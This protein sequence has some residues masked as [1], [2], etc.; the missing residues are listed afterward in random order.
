MPGKDYYQILGVKRDAT[1]KE[2]RQAYRKLARKYHPD[3]NPGNKAAEARFKEIGEAYEVLSDKEKRAKYD[4]FGD[5]WQ[6]AGARAPGGGA[7]GTPFDFGG[8]PGNYQVHFEDLGGISEE[9]FGGIFDQIFGAGRARQAARRPRRGRDY[10]QPVEVT[11]EEAFHGTTRIMQLEGTEP[12]PA[13]GG[14]GHVKGQV[15]VD[16]RGAGTRVRPRRLEVKIPAGVRDGSRVRIAGEGGPGASG[17]QKGDL[18]LV[19]SVK[20]HT[21]FERKEDD[22][23]EEVPVLLTVA[24][25]GGEVQVPTP[26]GR[27]A[28]RIPPETQNGRTFRL[29]GQ[30]MPHLQGTGA[31]D[32]YAKIKVVLPTNLSPRERELFQELDRAREVKV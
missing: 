21:L 23:Y 7:A 30:G 2:I 20:P 28:L 6:Y 9:G 29:S 14:A 25:L 5:A 11:L 24:I 27:V 15:C 26:K 3:V 18:Y 1:E 8:G 10:E 32:L 22:L 13:C 19:V 16:C 31:G 4:Q 17:G 12:C